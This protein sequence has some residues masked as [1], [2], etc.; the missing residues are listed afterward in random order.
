MHACIKNQINIIEELS[1]DQNIDPNIS[2]NEGNTSLHHSAALGH[3]R[4]VQTLIERFPNIQIDKVN[5]LGQT[6]LIR[7]AI[8]GKARCAH[9]LLKA[10]N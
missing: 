4:V 7:A 1:L 2:D 6:A 5:K 3:V 10:G 9:L 8:Q